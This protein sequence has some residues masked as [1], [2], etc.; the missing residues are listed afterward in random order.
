MSIFGS[1]TGY[2]IYIYNVYPTFSRVCIRISVLQLNQGCRYGLIG[3]NGSGK[4][5]VLAALAQRDLPLPSHIDVYH[6]HEEAPANDLTGVEAVITHI[7]E[8]AKKLEEL[9]EQII[10]E[11]GAD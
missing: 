2:I 5:N 3:L 8:E 1:D 10:E 6:L 7:I 9:S 4:S 11:F